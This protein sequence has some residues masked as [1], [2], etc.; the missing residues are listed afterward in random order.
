ME[1]E[2]NLVIIKPNTKKY[3]IK[4][5]A[6]I[7][8]GIP[9]LMEN[10]QDSLDPALDP[11]LIKNIFKKGNTTYLQMGE[12]TLEFSDNFRFYLT[13]K[14]RNPHY[15]PEVCTKITLVN[16][17]ITK[18]GLNDQLLGILVKMERPELE[19]ARDRLITQSAEDAKIQ[20]DLER[21]IL[22]VLKDAKNILEDASA[23]E[24]LTR[25]KTKSNEIAE[26]QEAAKIT[27]KNISEAR[28]K[29]ILAS[30]EAS[31]LFFVVSVLVNIDPM[32]QYSLPYFIN[33]YRLAVAQAEKSDDL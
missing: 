23:I 4:L 19:E 22:N 2:F 7:Q 8:N 20:Q 16:F 11:V 9:M 27:Q 5:E 24:I 14:L 13:T 30:E 18:E 21:Q 1:K 31:C 29:Y 3:G 25:A 28:S 15:M 6:A 10:V 12:K 33:I 32:Y 26:Q 17:V